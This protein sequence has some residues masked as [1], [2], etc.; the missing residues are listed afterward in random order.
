M[1]P[2]PTSL[3]DARRLHLAGRLSDA[4]QI[5]DAILENEPGNDRALHLRGMLALQ[6][7]DNENA[8]RLVRQ[9]RSRVPAPEPARAAYNTGTLCLPRRNYD[10]PETWLRTAIDHGEQD[11][12]EAHA[13]RANILARCRR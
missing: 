10:L 1:N 12:W 9:T 4:R 13:N 8:E 5:Y 6:E 11:N 7:G 2:V 3:D